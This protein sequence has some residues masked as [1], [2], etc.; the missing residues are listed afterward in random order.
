M[1]SVIFVFNKIP[2]II[3]CEKEDLM[4]NICLKFSSI[5]NNEFDKLFF[6]YKGKE[7]NYNLTFNEQA[8]EG[9]KKN[10]KMNVLVYQYKDNNNNNENKKLTK[11][12]DIICP[13]C[14]ESCLLKIKDYQ[15]SFYGCKNND[16]LNNIL[17]D[18]YEKIQKLGQSKII[19]NNCKN[20][21]NNAKNDV[22]YNCLFCNINLCPICKSK[23]DKKHNIIN[24]ELKNFICKN[25]NEKFNS[26]CKKCKLNL[27]IFC[28]SKHEDKDN[29]IYYKN[30]IPKKD[31][32]E[33]KIE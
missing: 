28:E 33:N 22:F 9:D 24:Y 11:S 29:L 8:K 32:N 30:I 4:K 12:K 14:G 15:I 3:Q 19:C 16:E 27:C 21:K 18:E 25:H 31:F 5:I 26:Y 23:H 6:L 17:L 1:A 7:I 13:K 2:T 10:G 20:Y